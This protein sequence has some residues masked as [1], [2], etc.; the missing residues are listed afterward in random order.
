MKILDFSPAHIEQAMQ[1]AK[2]DYDTERGFVPDLPP[3]SQVPD[4]ARY[5][6]NG[7]GV[8][9]FEG[10][11][12]VGFLCS[13]KPFPNCFGSTDAVGVFSPM[14]ANGA[15]SKNRA[16][17]YALM[18]QTAGEKW[19]RAGA[20]S[21]GVCL[22]AH[23]TQ[24]QQRFFRY[25][26]GLR[27]IDAIRGMDEIE[28]PPCSGYDFAEVKTEELLEILPL[29]HLLDAHMAASPTFILRPSDT[30][31]SFLKKAEHYKSIYFA[32]RQ[33]GKIIAYLRAELDGETFVCNT[34][35]YLHV[36]GAFCLPEHRGKGLNKTLLAMLIHTLKD[37]GYTRLGVDFESIN[38]TA[39]G[40]WPKYFS[41]YTHSVVRRIDEHAVNRHG[42]IENV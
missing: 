24:A 27:C 22:Y 16:E 21:H 13:T 9:A 28:A 10:E 32:A 23:D 12:M 15:V 34:P 3:I 37:R 31:E 29:D 36:K 35:G 11:T 4:L 20:A 17:I 19:A 14:G 25:G 40:F 33:N 6:E 26:Y 8:A 7:F 18:V 2:R 39:Y 5:A 30:P 41:V 38:P 1:I 42:G